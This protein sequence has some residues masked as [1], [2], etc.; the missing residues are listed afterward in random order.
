MGKAKAGAA[1]RDKLKKEAKRPIEPGRATLPEDRARNALLD[2]PVKYRPRHRERAPRVRIDQPEKLSVREVEQRLMRAMQ[3]LRAL[4][5]GDR[6]MLAMRSP[7]PPYVQ[8]Y[9][10]A[11]G[12][13]VAE[14]PRFRPTPFDVSDFLVALSW[15]QHLSKSDW[16]IL[17]WRSFDLSFG[18][19]AKYIGRSDETARRRYRDTVIDVWCAANNI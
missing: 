14:E 11:Y 4:P 12:S 6:R 8:E 13:V 1:W 15:A 18:L 3:T 17:W 16:R 10:D 5:D 2:K 9:I 7:W 19:I